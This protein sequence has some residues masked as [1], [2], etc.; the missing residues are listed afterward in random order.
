MWDP[1]HTEDSSSSGYRITRLVKGD[2]WDALAWGALVKPGVNV[3]VGDVLLKINGRRLTK[4]RGVSEALVG[5]GGKEVSLTFRVAD[6][7]EE[8][9]RNA[10]RDL[11]VSDG[12][13]K[14]DELSAKKAAPKKNKKAA[15]AT[16]THPKFTPNPSAAKPDAR[17]APGSVVTV[18]VRAMHSELD[19]RYKDLVQSRHARV[20]HLS[21]DEVGY[22][23][24]PDMERFGYGEF[25]RRF[26]KESK[27]KAL[28]V[29]LRG[30]CLICDISTNL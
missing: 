20:S 12:K 25:W 13:K 23:H 16:M 28:V 15:K 24:V 7:D 8:D 29:D 22:L 17:R 5:L 30:N 14:K 11:R 2:A 18:R 3:N 6:G 9:V 1:G 27:K 10:M 21:N 26:P 4:T 19:A